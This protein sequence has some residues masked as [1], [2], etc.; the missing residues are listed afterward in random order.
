L[1]T[2]TGISKLD[3]QRAKCV[4]CVESHVNYY[5]ESQFRSGLLK[6]FVLLLLNS[7]EL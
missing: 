5:G 3:N 7:P 2:P 1:F 6:P 4:E